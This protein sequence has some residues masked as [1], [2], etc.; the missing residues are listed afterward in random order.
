MPAPRSGCDGSFNSSFLGENLDQ[1]VCDFDK[2]SVV[3]FLLL[4]RIMAANVLPFDPPQSQRCP[5]P[6]NFLVTIALMDAF[7]S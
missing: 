6:H 3:T 2:N 7:F 4:R 5:Q 1:N